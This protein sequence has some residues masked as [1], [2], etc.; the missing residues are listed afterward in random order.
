[1]AYCCDRLDD[2]MV[3]WFVCLWDA[4]VCDFGL[5]KQFS[6]I[7]RM[8]WAI[9]VVTWKTVV[10][11]AMWTIQAQLERFQ[12]G[13]ISATGRESI[14]VVSWPKLWLLSVLLQICLKLT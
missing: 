10:L 1:M 3:C 2:D 8:Q 5:E 11:K 6:S 13:S 12:K 14:C 4:D 7:S 9:L